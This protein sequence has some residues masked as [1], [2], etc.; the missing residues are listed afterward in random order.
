MKL[1]FELAHASCQ[2]THVFFQTLLRRLVVG[3]DALFKV[4]YDLLVVVFEAFIVLRHAL[5]YQFM[6]FDFLF[7]KLKLEF[8]GH[9]LRMLLCF[10]LRQQR[11]Q[12]G[13]LAL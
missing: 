3:V 4:L 1:C 8:F 11:G 12:L 10:I 2:S 6:E 9:A 7:L 5:R 13:E